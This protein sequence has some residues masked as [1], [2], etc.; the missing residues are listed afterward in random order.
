MAATTSVTGGM[1]ILDR[2]FKNTVDNTQG[3]AVLLSGTTG[4]IKLPTGDNPSD[5]PI[6]VS[7]EGN[8]SGFSESVRLIGSE[9]VQAGGTCTQGKNAIVLNTG[10]VK[11]IVTNST[12]AQQT[13]LG[14]FLSAGATGDLVEV[15]IRP[16]FVTL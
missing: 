6:G 7:M 12:P 8:K 9:L 13:V 4:S 14:P 10:T 5:L 2:A 3:R 16:M 1:Q 15:F 11:D